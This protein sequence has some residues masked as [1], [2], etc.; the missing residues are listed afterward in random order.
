L[1]G[2]PEYF[3]V[4]VV[5]DNAFSA[6]ASDRSIDGLRRRLNK[7]IGYEFHFAKCSDKIRRGFLEEVAQDQFKYAGFAVDKKR[8]FAEC[9]KKPKYV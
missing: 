3:T 7:P 6:D 8:L 1:T 4:A 5:F 2:C 9:F